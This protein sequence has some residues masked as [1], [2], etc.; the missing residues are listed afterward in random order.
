MIP[1]ARPTW[2]ALAFFL[3]GIAMLAMVLVAGRRRR[4]AQALGDAPLVRRLAGEELG[5]FPL[6]R[7]LLVSVALAALGIAAA[8][9]RWGPATEGESARGADVVLVLDASASMLA[10]DVRPNRLET[11]RAEARR[12]LAEMAGER[13]G[14][15]VFAGRGYVLSPLTSDH[16]ALQLYL[17]NLSPDIVAQGGSSLSAALR[18]A[19]G[20]LAGGPAPRGRSGSVVLVSD[21][22]AL[23]EAEAVL[24]EARRASQLGI[25]VHTVG[26]GTPGGAEIPDVDPATGRRRGVKREP[27]GEVAISR[28][29]EALL[30]EVARTSGGLYRPAGD[31]AAARA[32][33]EEARS[34][35][36]LPERGEA[37][38]GMGAPVGGGGLEERYEWFVGLALALIAFD[39]LR[40][41]RRGV[42]R[43][44]TL[45]REV[46]G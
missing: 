31:P 38:P 46:A 12:L 45:E 1:F 3:P 44:R 21:G 8:G 17:D 25:T 10:E 37:P 16:G 15:V 4:A 14:I 41:R 35:A 5:S 34:A 27:T 43:A 39:S 36:A 30:R 13:V 42:Q 7:T 20:L 11:E 18:Q 23:E 29:G 32:I 2:V 24:E 33:A 28:L 40:E 9:P 22:D 19:Q 6:G 26:V